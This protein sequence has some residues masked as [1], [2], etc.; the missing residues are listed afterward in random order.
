MTDPKPKLKLPLRVFPSI[1][2]GQLTIRDADDHPIEITEHLA[3]VIVTALTADET[4]HESLAEYARRIQ[5]AC[6]YEHSGRG[7][8]RA[9]WVSGLRTLKRRPWRWRL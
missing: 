9:G 7:E 6:D 1:F 4:I 5:A 3:E 8:G 2:A